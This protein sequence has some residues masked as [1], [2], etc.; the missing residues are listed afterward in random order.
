MAQIFSPTADTWLRAIL[1]A[2]VLGT[3]G[4]LLLGGTVARSQYMTEVARTPMQPVPFSHKHHAGELGIDCRYC[5]TSVETSADAGFPATHV[6][7]TCHSQL[8]TN[9]AM[10]APVRQSLAENRSLNWK[11]VARVPDFVYF[12]HDIHVAKG[13]SCFEC[14][15][16]VDRMPLM[17]RAKAFEM[18][19]C[20]DCHRDPAPHLRPQAAVLEAD[21][22]PP[23]DRRALGERLMRLYRIKGPDEL[24]HCAVCHR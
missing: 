16:R 2:L 11:R 5:H 9:A 19:W 1:I 8:W 4:S 6:C 3:V 17:F 14:H 12:R 13:V 24:T 22:T 15:G 10:L 21:W 20:L 7:M 23:A 18:R